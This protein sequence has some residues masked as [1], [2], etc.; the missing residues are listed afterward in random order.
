MPHRGLEAQSV[1]RVALKK[2]GGEGTWSVQVPLRHL[3]LVAIGRFKSV[4]AY[5]F[6]QPFRD[7]LPLW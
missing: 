1:D 2:Q 3:N 7:A 4:W 6:S 5:A